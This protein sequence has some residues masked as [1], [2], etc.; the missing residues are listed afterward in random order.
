MRV[1]I[2]GGGTGG[3]LFPGIAIA[4]ELRARGHEVSFVG[5]ERGIEAK[6]LPKEGWP[7][8]LIQVR[9]L[10]GGGVGGA[11][12][13]LFAVP[14]AL[15]QCGT[16][17]K[18]LAPELVIGVGGYASGPMVL[19]AAMARLPTAIL[20]Q[21]SVPG[22]TNRMLGKV[23]RLVVGGF[24]SAE[25]FFPKQ[26]YRLLGN[27]V[28]IKVRAGMAATQQ[29]TRTA[30]GGLLIVGGS[31]GAHAVNELVFG[32]LEI[33]HQ[34]GMKLPVV[35]QTGV[36]DL[37]GL[38]A[39]YAAAGIAVD[40][41][42]FIDDMAAAYRGARLCVAR[43]GASTLAELTTLGVPSLLI[44]LPSAA[45]DH[46]TA[47]ARDLEGAG[48]AMVVVQNETTPTSLADAIAALYSDDGKLTQMS[49]AALSMARPQAHREITDAL[50]A[51]VAQP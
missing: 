9:A 38:V 48:A 33:L 43:A 10:K 18:E 51:L 26:K 12:K 15:G 49:A 44:P 31:Q 21:N 8:S 34:R 2:A 40:A 20:E 16:I 24:A 11:L 25:R 7:L 42:A 36:A 45:D 41:R 17:L 1:V 28:R 13:G 50:L 46:Q 23:V 3:H 19:R 6:V 39:R 5:T 29:D 22:I 27:P 4:E 32:A 47:N 37:E 35:H 14:R 30:T